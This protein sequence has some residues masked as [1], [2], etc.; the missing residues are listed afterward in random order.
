MP[1]RRTV[2]QNTAAA[3]ALPPLMASTAGTADELSLASE[4]SL[5]DQAKRHGLTYGVAADHQVL[6][7]DPRYAQALARDGALLATENNA[8]WERLRPDPDRFDFTRLD[9]MF[10]FAEAHDMRMRCHT[11]AWHSQLPPW[12]DDVVDASNAEAML[13]QHIE[14]VAGRYAGRV[15][16][17]DVV[18]EAIWHE[19]GRGD[20]LRTSPWLRHLGTGYVELAFRTARA[21]DP[22]ALLVYNDFGIEYDDVWH[23]TRRDMVLDL[24]TGLLSHDVPLD[25]VGIQAHLEGHRPSAFGPLLAFIDELHALGLEVMITELD[26]SD[27]KLPAEIDARDR[28][29][30]EAY[31]GFLNAVL[32]HPAVTTVVSWGFADPHSWLNE[33]MP[34]DDGLPPRP[35][36]LDQD[37]RRKPA[38]HAIAKALSA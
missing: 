37:Y 24:V 33:F 30:A 2:L 38:W 5:R 29:I 1:S 19:D 18:N 32:P 35:L 27:Q 11:L 26:V 15:H 21:A 3:V 14:T 23:Q 9:G 12:F 36:P 20:G 6:A 22:D 28:M 34:R 7:A 16:S 31:T 8:K 10:R 17:W 25:A 13:V 4:L